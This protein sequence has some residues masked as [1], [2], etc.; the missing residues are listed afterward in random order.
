MTMV[1][2]LGFRSNVGGG[3]VVVVMVIPVDIS[4]GCEHRWMVIAVVI[5]LVVV[6]K[7]DP[8]HNIDDCGGAS[9]GGSRRYLWWWW[10]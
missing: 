3:D 2:E 7:A 8:G 6:M 4:C 1:S 5:D 10:V 9:D